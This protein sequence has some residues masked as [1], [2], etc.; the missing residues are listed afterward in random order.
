MF[1]MR[2]IIVLWLARKAWQVARY[3]WR[4]RRAATNRA[5]TVNY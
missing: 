5:R 3:W 1:R 4:R 2:T